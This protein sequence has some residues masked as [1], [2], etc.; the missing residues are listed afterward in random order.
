[1]IRVWT[2]I[3]VKR[4]VPLIAKIVQQ[5][6]SFFIIRYLSES[7]DKIWR[8]E[9]ETYKIEEDQIEEDLGTTRETDVG[10]RVNGDDGFFKDELSDD[11][12]NV[13]Q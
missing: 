5:K 7:D 11:E 2:D 6:G 8:Y 4:P 9:D 1:M 13:D 12:N 10:F 3:G